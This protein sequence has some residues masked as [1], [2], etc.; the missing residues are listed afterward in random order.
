MAMTEKDKKMISILGVVVVGYLIYDYA[1]PMFD[2]HQKRLTDI[3]GKVRELRDAH[4][5]AA[6]LGKLFQEVRQVRQTLDS[7]KRRIPNELNQ[8][9]FLEKVQAHA[10][11][12][13]IEIK[14]ITYQPS[15]LSGPGYRSE[16]VIV[17]FTGPW[18]NVMGFLWR[19]QNFE[20]LLDI[21]SVRL[22]A[23]ENEKLGG[24]L[25][26]VQL[27]ANIFISTDI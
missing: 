4:D 10:R 2:E 16:T 13:T 25:Y 3:E 7:V 26:S 17:D 18:V 12:E 1:M 11:T 23:Q 21:V 5:K 27:A 20:R 6:N 19:L 8:D 9:D 14:A 22:A 24:Y 15:S